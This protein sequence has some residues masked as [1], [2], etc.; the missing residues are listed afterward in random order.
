M[1]SALSKSARFR[2]AIAVA[3]SYA[4]CVVAPSVT[5]A[6]A[7]ADVV[8]HCLSENHGIAAV[9]HDAKT[10]VH[11]DGTAHTHSVDHASPKQGHN[12][13]QGQ[14]ST[15]CGLFSVVGIAGEPA[16][17]LGAFTRAS[18]TLPALQDAMSGCGPERIN[19]PPIA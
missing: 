5:F 13:G 4:L 10:H 6:F 16:F 12:D 3:V 11:A 9:H 17:S 15:C 18:L 8:A 14:G 7:D 2:A 19:R 1:F